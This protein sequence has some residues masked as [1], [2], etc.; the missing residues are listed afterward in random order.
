MIRAA[1][2]TTSATVRNR[3]R[4]F[5][6]LGVS[7]MALASGGPEAAGAAHRLVQALDLGPGGLDERRDDQLA[8]AFAAPDDEIL[9]AVIDQD[10]LHLAAVVGIDGAGRI[11]AG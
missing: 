2:P 8:D 9:F 5:R 6:S 4:R 1:I 3:R 11:Q 7:L 10:H